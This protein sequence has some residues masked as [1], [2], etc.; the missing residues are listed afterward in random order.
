MVHEFL[1]TL[2]ELVSEVIRCL[3]SPVPYPVSAILDIVDN[4]Y[5]IALSKSIWVFMILS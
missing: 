5:C 1:I 4:L 2:R 3:D